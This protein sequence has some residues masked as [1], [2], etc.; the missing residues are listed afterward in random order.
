MAGLASDGGE[1]EDRGAGGSIW[2]CGVSPA[3]LAWSAA[4]AVAAGVA[5]VRLLRMPGHPA[6][7]VKNGYRW[8]AIAASCWGVG[9]I[10][11]QVFGGLIGIG[12]PF[13]AADLVSFA[14]LPALVLGLATLTG[15][16]AE[17]GHGE[18]AR[19]GQHAEDPGRVAA[20]QAYPIAADGGLLVASLF[21]IGWVTL[22]GR[23]YAG[24]GV[25][26]ASFAFHL[27]R[28]TADLIA[29]AVLLPFAARNPRLA[30][31]PM[32]TVAAMTTSDS[33]AVGARIAGA[34]IGPVPSLFWVAGLCL[35]AATPA[36][37]GAIRLPAADE[38]APVSQAV[39]TSAP[40]GERAGRTA[41]LGSRLSRPD[42]SCSGPTTLIALGAATTAA[43]V[44][45]GFALGGGPVASPAL[46]VSGAILVLALVLRLAG[47]ARQVSAVALTARDSERM[48][49]ALADTTSDAVVVCDLAG[50][51]EYASPVVAEYG[52]VPGRLIGARLADLVHPED[53]GG[54]IRAA[55]ALL[56][57][58]ADAPGEHRPA[59]AAAGAGGYSGP[60]REAGRA[61]SAATFAGRVRSAD[62]SWRHVEC[63]LS[64]YGHAGQP[65]RLLVTARD[66]SDRVALRRQLTH[67]TFH[68]GLTGLPNRTFVE[69]RV[70][71][72]LGPPAPET[73]ET[74]ETRAD[75]PERE[76]AGG[77]RPVVAQT[78]VLAGPGRVPPVAGAIL[79]DLDGYTAVNELIGHG[80]GDLL[81]AQAGRRLRAAAPPQATVAR[82]GG[83]EFAIL[84]TGA[85]SEKDVVDLADRLASQ[86]AAE[87]FSAAGV[88][89]PLTASVG[90]ALTPASSADHLLSN[91][92]VAM[93]R[94]KEAG[95]GRVEVFAEQMHADVLR[96]LEVAA[97]LQQAITGQHLEIEYQPVVELATSR[98]T[99]V[100]A[101]VRWRRD[102]EVMRPAEFL[103]VAEDCG[104]IVPLGDWV[105]REACRQVAAWHA[106]G[107][108]IGLAVNLS[109]RQ[110]GAPLADPGGQRAGTDRQRR[111]DRHRAG[112]APRRGHQ[113][114]HRRLRHGIRLAEL[115]AAA[116]RRHHQDRPGVR[117]RAWHRPDPDP[118]HQDHRRCLSRPRRRGGGRGDRTARPARPAPGD[119]V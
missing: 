31:L 25:G 70:K 50:S 34:A 21:V 118:A 24:A 28:P 110:V 107:L 113:A 23:E 36:G 53:R 60:G 78:Q 88:Q 20:G 99:A 1:Q 109:V 49:R 4:G 47:L 73:P 90:V 92:D 8:L 82:W 62:G 79:V 83:D 72:L 51:V 87:P 112:R 94:A 93:S 10:A 38:L 37:P 85:E 16:R 84:V 68:D 32:L 66:V 100:E 111:P 15:W 52:Y 18:L 63:A 46:A 67:L 106:T 89:I 104:L 35:L 3:V 48:F 97:G 29:V 7:A 69:E 64:R 19:I 13:Q 40:P 6:P 9:G 30:L 115:P 76:L 27:I 39:A 103:A 17:S 41:Q 44:V 105:L 56:R 43:L 14:A 117:R 101:L 61:P 86:I 96:R 12:S 65:V 59:N 91:A 114:G 45:T 95:G 5:A 80:G 108:R 102:G 77:Q 58:A 75:R 26:A 71:D 116:S 54:A 81:I 98:I 2:R 119:G 42:G 22:F 11:Q 33:L 74:A 57:A 55:L